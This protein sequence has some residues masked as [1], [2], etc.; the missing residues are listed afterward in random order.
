[1]KRRLTSILFIAAMLAAPLPAHALTADDVA[2]KMNTEQLS[3]WLAGA[4]EMA[5]LLFVRM[6][7]AE[8]VQCIKAWTTGDT[9]TYLRTV[10]DTMRANPKLQAAAVYEVLMK[11]Q[12][13]E[14][15]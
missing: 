2:N 13:G 15:K 4:D 10:L 3:A 12:C 6:G 9:R 14:Y 11:R 7:D 8:R 1:M 5:M